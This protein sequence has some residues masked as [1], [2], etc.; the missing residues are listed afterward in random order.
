MYVYQASDVVET[1]TAAKNL[2]AAIKNFLK[3]E[4]KPG[5]KGERF[6][7]DLRDLAPFKNLVKFQSY[8]A[9]ALPQFELHLLVLVR[10]AHGEIL[11]KVIEQLFAKYADDFNTSYEKTAKGINITNAAKFEQIVKSVLADIPNL[12]TAQQIKPNG[13]IRNAV[14]F[15]TFEQEV[16]KAASPIIRQQASSEVEARV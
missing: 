14:L 1:L 12:L 2:N 16:L 10:Y 4:L 8:I 7:K 6:V 15:L 13:F 9:A 5:D 3:K 11:E